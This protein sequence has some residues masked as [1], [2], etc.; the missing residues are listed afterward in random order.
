MVNLIS[1]RT[2]IAPF[3]L[4]LIVSS[5]AQSSSQ[6]QP[7]SGA[8][9]GI[10]GACNPPDYGSSFTCSLSVGYGTGVFTLSSGISGVAPYTMYVYGTPDGTS[11]TSAC[12]GQAAFP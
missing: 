1:C 5:A 6:I 2:A 12:A 7:P 8:S 10:F 3:H 4:H 9:V 11:S